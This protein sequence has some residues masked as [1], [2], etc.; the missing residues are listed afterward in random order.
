[1]NGSIKII[2]IVYVLWTN[3]ILWLDFCKIVKNFKLIKYT[4]KSILVFLVF[5]TSH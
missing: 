1:M 2:A 3:M 4:P 5:V